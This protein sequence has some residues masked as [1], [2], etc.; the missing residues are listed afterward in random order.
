MRRL[1]Q[2]NSLAGS[3][4][5][6]RVLCLQVSLSLQTRSPIPANRIQRVEEPADQQSPPDTARSHARRLCCC[7]CAA[8][9]FAPAIW[10]STARR[11]ARGCDPG[12]RAH[13]QVSAAT[14]ATA[15]ERLRAATTWGSALPPWCA[16]KP[17]SAASSRLVVRP[18]VL[19]CPPHVPAAPAP[20]LP[21]PMPPPSVPPPAERRPAADAIKAPTIDAKGFLAP[22]RQGTPPPKE[23][24]GCGR[25]PLWVCCRWAC[26]GR[27]PPLS[28]A[29]PAP[30]PPPPPLP[31]PPSPQVAQ[32]IYDAG[33]EYGCF[34][35]VN[36]GV[37]LDLIAAMKAQQRAFFA[38][39]REAK[40]AGARA[41]GEEAG[42]GGADRREGSPLGWRGAADQPAAPRQP[43]SCRQPVSHSP[44]PCAPPLPP[45]SSAPQPTQT[46]GL[47]TSSRSG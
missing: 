15:A 46:D 39:P 44:R 47:T 4:H 36:H 22:E 17:W 11:D 14:A 23:A 35:L 5:L 26:P 28:R 42:G 21:V 43:A 7:P 10:P 29:A 34:Q 13:P 16:P 19:R 18:Q 38:L 20:P 37:S 45:Q 2:A 6:Q 40:A 32:A 12:R 41:A 31:T 8:A 30:H 25:H 3:W 1:A 9:G 33:A 27:C 24:S